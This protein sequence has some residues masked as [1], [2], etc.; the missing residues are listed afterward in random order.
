MGKN[1]LNFNQKIDYI[2]PHDRLRGKF[3]KNATFFSFTPK[4]N[5]SKL[6]SIEG[7]GKILD[8]QLI[9]YSCLADKPER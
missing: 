2:M 9:R 8:Y 6:Q 5:P 1:R 3:W 7:L 4:P